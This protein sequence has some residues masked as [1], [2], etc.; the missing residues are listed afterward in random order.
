MGGRL[1]F[2]AEDGTTGNELW[3]SD[4]TAAGTVL[5][6]D[7]RPGTSPSYP[8]YLTAMGGRLYF[9]AEDGTTGNELWTSDGTAAGTVLVKDI[10]PGTS[11]SNPLSLTAVG[12]RLYFIADDGTTGHELWTSDGTAAGTVL[13]KDILPGTSGS[14]PVNL[15]DVG[16][17][18]YFTANAGT[19]GD[20][21]WTSD[22]TAAGTVLVKDIRPGMSGASPNFLTDVGGRLYFRASDGTTGNELWT[23]DGTTAGTVLVTDIRPGTSGSSPSNLTA[24]GSSLYFTANDGTT[25]FELW[26]LDT[27]PPPGYGSSPAPGATITVGSALIGTPVS[28]TLSVSE[29]GDAPLNVTGHSLSGTN[30]SDFSVSPATLSIADGGAAQDLTITCTPA[31]AGLRTATLT[32]T[33]DA[34]GSPA[35][36]TLACTGTLPQVTVAASPANALEDGPAPLVYTVTRSGSTSGAVTVDFT[37]SGTA[38]FDTDYTQSGAATFAGTVLIPNGQASATVTIA[39]AADSTLEPDETVILTIVDG[40]GYTA[41]TL[42]SASATIIDDDS[43]A[44]TVSVNPASVVEDGN[45]TLA[46]TF[47]RNGSVG[48]TTV[49]FSVG[50]TATFDTDYAA[51]GATTF[52]GSS[53]T[54]VISDGQSN[55]TV[56]I[57]PAVDGTVEANETVILTVVD[58]TG[59]SAGSPASATGTLTND[60]QQAPAITSAAPADGSYGTVYSHTFTATG[61]PVPTWSRSGTLP[62]GLSFDPAAGTLSG[63]PTTAGT[64]P[65]I[66]VTAS[67]GVGQDAT[68]TFAIVIAK[69]PLPTIFIP[70]VTR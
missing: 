33:H 16:S 47:S 11:A 66:T 37:L 36:Y 25:G 57:D 14:N 21:L 44:V 31:S 26:T 29:T 42:A 40:T 28:T 51:N 13:L 41:G 54:M 6:T 9:A 32:V 22:G 19:T 50:G 59:Y 52:G 46:Y 1:Y 20:E 12:G 69:A 49:A 2:Q 45:V 60:D 39:P 17:S 18:L 35:S 34:P 24:V 27:T 55:A 23:S 58:G 10:V 7:I 3:T 5:V 62:P 8:S 53:G 30:A 61:F 56:T 15:T 67:N 64:Y 70:L 43:Y 48:A 38:T 63:T 68:Q 65:N 4:G